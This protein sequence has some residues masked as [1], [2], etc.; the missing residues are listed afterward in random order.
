M[1]ISTD[2]DNMATGIEIAGVVLAVLPLFISALDQT[3]DG[4]DAFL[5]F[6]SEL[7]KQI[8]K[9]RIQHLY[10][11]ATMKSL[12]S[13]IAEAE[14]VNEM[15]LNPGGTCWEDPDMQRRLEERLDEAYEEYRDT[16]TGIEKIM[17][18]IS[19]YLNIDKSEKASCECLVR[20]S[21]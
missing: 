2:D 12:L 18:T 17:K 15:I 1:I 9:L 6:E 7:P 11:N 14:Q 3:S 20:D 13:S 5:H 16:I 8:R 21:N 10:Y 19:K 4:M